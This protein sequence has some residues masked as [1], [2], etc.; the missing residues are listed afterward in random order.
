MKTRQITDRQL[1][2]FIDLTAWEPRSG[3][4]HAVAYQP[5]AGRLLIYLAAGPMTATVTVP[6]RPLGAVFRELEAASAALLDEQAEHE[7][8]HPRRVG[9]SNAGRPRIDTGTVGRGQ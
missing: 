5:H 3:I 9:K 1:V 7:A 4:R 6:E 8:A 2:Q